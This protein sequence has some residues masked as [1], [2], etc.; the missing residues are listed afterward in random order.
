M[1]RISMAGA[2][3]AVT[4]GRVA[5][6]V[7]EYAMLLGRAGTTDTVTVPVAGGGV[8]DE[9][10]LLL[11]PA[12]QIAITAN[13]ELHLERV[14]LTGVDETVALLQARIAAISGHATHRREP[15][16]D[17]ADAG[18][19]DAAAAFPDFEEYRSDVEPDG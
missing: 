3:V 14:P 8:A 12:S 7:L 6:L 17:H 13:D 4:D 9:A 19:P 5:D 10:R 11:G 15:A 1:R 16:G 18:L 2:D